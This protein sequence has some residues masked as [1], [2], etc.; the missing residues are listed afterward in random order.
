MAHT[1]HT[2]SSRPGDGRPVARPA[3][4]VSE[5]RRIE[6][7]LADLSGARSR[8]EDL[9]RDE[10]SLEERARLISILHQLR[11]EASAARGFLVT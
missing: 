2:H 9:R 4:R 8:F 3:G 6:A 1:T 7:V 10:G 5:A 11:A